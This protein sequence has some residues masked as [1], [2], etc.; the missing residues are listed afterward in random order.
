[1]NFLFDISYAKG[2]GPTIFGQKLLQWFSLQTTT[3]Y[4]TGTPY[5]ATNV[6]G[7]QIGPTNG[8]RE[9][10]YFQTDLSLTRTIPFEDL[11]GPGMSKV[12]LDLQLEITNIFN[13]TTPLSVYAATGEGNNDGNPNTFS[14]STEY[15]NDPTNS[16]GNSIDALG[17]LFYDP[18]LDLN[19]SGVVTVA[20]QEIAYAQYR[21]DEFAQEVN[22]QT[23]RRVW[24]N[25]TIRF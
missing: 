2:E 7:A 24:M 20:E 18:R 9:P 8:D 25:F 23:P 11:F 6:K 12:F 15:Y 1:L 3:V 19:H 13:R 21:S 4:Q 10:D 17:N 22:Y 5:T 14:T 16:R